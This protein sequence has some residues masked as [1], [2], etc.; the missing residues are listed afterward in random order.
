MLI[1][2]RKIIINNPGRLKEKG[3]LLLA[4]NHPNSFLD[5]VIL[6]ALL[7]Q[8]VWSLARGDVFKNRFIKR[9]LSAMKI[10]PVYRTSEGSHHLSKNY[11][12]FDACTSI[13]K[14]NGIVMIF[15]EGMCINEWH[16]R[17]LK[18]GTARLAIKAWEEDISLKV[19]PVGINYSSFRRFGKNIFINF[20]KMITK[21]DFDITQADGLRYQDFNKKIKEQL[22]QLVFEIPKTDIKKQE[23]L[24]KVKQS[25]FKQIFLA[26]LAG[27][28]WLFHVPLYLPL[29]RF[30]WKRTAHIDHYDSVL[31]A[32]LLLT[33]PLYLFILTVLVLLLT[34]QWWVISIFA[35]FPFTAWCYVQLKPQLDR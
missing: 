3:P 21:E 17:P 24:L 8:P 26:I 7:E 20:G 4:C 25:L 11:K 5:S 15:S 19:L 12:T 14:E 23:E 13:F 9:L 27:A 34:K 22:E 35:L 33:Y 1:F 31:I 32:I 29:K 30:T 2:C 6:D 10:L 18:K 16:L 28:G